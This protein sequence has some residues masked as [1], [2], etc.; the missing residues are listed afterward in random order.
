MAPGLL[1][2]VEGSFV[3]QQPE[4]LV[5]T[6]GGGRP[7]AHPPHETLAAGGAALH[8][9]NAESIAL[10]DDIHFVTFVQAVALA[11]GRWDRHLTLAVQPHLIS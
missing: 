4:K 11:K 10:L 6:Q 8:T 7:A 3:T 2:A 1:L 9:D 5:S